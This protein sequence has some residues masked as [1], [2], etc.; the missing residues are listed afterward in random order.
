MTYVTL[1][2]LILFLAAVLGAVRIAYMF[3][4]RA[5]RRFAAKWG[6]QYIGPTAA[7]RWWWNTSQLVTGPPVPAW[8]SRFGITQIWNVIEG[9]K[10][11]KRIII[12]DSI[13]GDFRSR[14]RTFIMCQTGQNPFETDSSVDRVVQTHG[15]TVL[16]GVWFL[17]FSWIMGTRRLDRHLYKLRF[18]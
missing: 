16:Q 3:R 12:F 9:T 18:E 2:K 6:L 11:G 13:V 10:D 1:L 14:A 4:A 15:W 17:W 8:V 5:M 7:P